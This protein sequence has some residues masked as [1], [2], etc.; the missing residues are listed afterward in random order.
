MSFQ[1]HSARDFLILAL[2]AALIGIAPIFVRFSELTP[3]WSLFYRMFLAL[4]FL[5][6]LNIFL[7]RKNPLKLKYSRSYWIAALAG[8]AFAGDMIGWHWSIS[9]TTVSNATIMVNTAPIYVAL[10]GFIV[11][12]EI[13]SL[14]LISALIFTYSGVIGLIYYSPLDGL[15]SIIGDLI[16]LV[17]G[18]L[19]AI[20]LIIIA[21][22][23]HE[24]PTKIIFY[25]TLFCCLFSLPSAFIESSNF[26]PSSQWQ[27]INLLMMAVLCQVGGQY[28]ITYAMPRIKASFAAFGLLMQPI[29]AT[30]LGSVLLFEFLTMEQYFFVVLALAGILFARLE[31]SRTDI[32]E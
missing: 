31:L 32:A 9:M 28:F 26:L 8:L 1:K 15:Q 3:S 11:L 22:L 10:F 25:T 17:A 24:S 14:K 4:P 2:G 13:V 16:S 20:Y 21:R 12:K 27:F 5:L 18:M 7:N 23:G 6:L 19:Y 30:I 29:T